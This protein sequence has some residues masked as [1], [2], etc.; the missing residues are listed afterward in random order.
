MYIHITCT[1]CVLA[2][3]LN[4]QVWYGNKHPK[5]MIQINYVL[6]NNNLYTCIVMSNQSSPV[7]GPVHVSYTF[8]HTL[9]T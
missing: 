6:H 7:C 1:T 8:V 2:P 9:R 5:I 3:F 4:K